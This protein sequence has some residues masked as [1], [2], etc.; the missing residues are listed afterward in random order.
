VVVGVDHV[1]HG[2]QVSDRHGH[3]SQLYCD[4]RRIIRVELE[5]L[6]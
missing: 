3:G 1:P 5:P 2:R 6:P 4:H